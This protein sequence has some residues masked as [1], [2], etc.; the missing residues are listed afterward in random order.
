MK[1]SVWSADLIL[2]WP[3]PGP[4]PWSPREDDPSASQSCPPSHWCCTPQSAYI[5]RVQSSVWRLPNYWP[6]NTPHTRHGVRGWGSIFRKTPDIGLASCIIPLHCTH[7]VHI[8]IVNLQEK[9]KRS[10]RHYTIGRMPPEERCG[11]TF[12]NVLKGDF[13][14]FLRP[15]FNTASSAAHQIPMCRRMLRSNPGLFRRCHWQPDALTKRLDLIHWLWTCSN[16][17]WRN[18]RLFFSSAISNMSPTFSLYF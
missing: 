8:K 1:T 18:I 15:V 9:N 5:Y 4:R 13:F 7:N 3:V 16:V 6:P 10:C 14:L 17:K 2:I 11:W 12:S